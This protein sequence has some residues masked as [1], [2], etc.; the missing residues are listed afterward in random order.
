MTCQEKN[1]AS[2]VIF[3]IQIFSDKNPV[4]TFYHQPPH[5]TLELN[6][7]KHVKRVKKTDTW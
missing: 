3:C 4:I 1:E 7:S 2:M 6:E 5:R